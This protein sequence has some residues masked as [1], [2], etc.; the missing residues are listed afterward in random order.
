MANTLFY[1]SDLYLTGVEKKELQAQFINPHLCKIQ[2]DFVFT[3]PFMGRPRTTGTRCWM[4]KWPRCGATVRSKSPS[5][6]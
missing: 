5:P 3:N 6:R 4:T 2:E 1:T